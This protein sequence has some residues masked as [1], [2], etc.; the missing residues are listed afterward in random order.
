VGSAAGSNNAAMSGYG[1]QRRFDDVYTQCMYTRGNKVPVRGDMQ[2]S[3]YSTQVPPPPPGYV[4][5]AGAVPPSGYGAP[6]D[7]IPPPGNSGPPPGSYR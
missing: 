5:P 1:A 4:A 7:Y 2:R 6:P 3:R